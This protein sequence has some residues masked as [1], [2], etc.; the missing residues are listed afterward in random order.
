MS[1]DAKAAALIDQQLTAGLDAGPTD[2]AQLRAGLDA[3]RAVLWPHALRN[4]PHAV[5]PIP[6]PPPSGD[7]VV[8]VN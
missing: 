2:T 6:P 7:V 1:I 3:A 8:V 5:S 4:K